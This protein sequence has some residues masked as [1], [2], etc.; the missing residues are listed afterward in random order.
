MITENSKNKSI[1]L[2]CLIVF[3]VIFY[4][5]FGLALKGYRL[6][7]TKTFLV[8][9]IVSA[10]F[11]AAWLALFLVQLF[12]LIKKAGLFSPRLAKRFFSYVVKKRV[13]LS[14]VF[15]ILYLIILFFGTNYF[16]LDRV[17]L[18]VF[19]V[20]SGT[21]LRIWALNFHLDKEIA[22]EIR[23]PYAFTRH[24]RYWGNLLTFFGFSIML[25]NYLV[26]IFF[27][28]LVLIPHIFATIDEEKN[29]MR[30][31]PLLFE[32]YKRGVNIVPRFWKPLNEDSVP[33]LKAKLSNPKLLQDHFKW[34]YFL[35][36]YS[37]MNL[38]LVL[39]VFAL[40][41]IKLKKR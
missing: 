6:R 33:K 1:F 39:G 16:S 22:I 41:I 20:A 28:V 11:L 15:A 4:L 34:S 10:I 32:E 3:I 17:I 8:T 40:L 23:G 30:K 19:F 29:I 37:I 36:K 13:S 25:E 38:V 14:S 35:N 18:F 7:H 12:S 24:P 31:W 2:L 9:I 26:W 27:I 5:W 21:I